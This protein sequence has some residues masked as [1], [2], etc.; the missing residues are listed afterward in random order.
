[1]NKK[2]SIK[3]AVQYV[4]NAEKDKCTLLGI[5]PMS[6]NFHRASLEISKE[7]DF[8]L[9]YIASRNQV[10][11]YKFGGGYVFNSDQKL[12]REKIEKICKEI[13]YDNVYYLCREHGGPWQRDKER[14]DHLPEDV[15]TLDENTKLQ[16]TELCGHYTYPKPEVEA[17][18]EKLYNNLNKVNINGRRYVVEKLKEEMQKH[19]RCFNLEGLTSKI[20]ASC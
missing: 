11:A 1:M 10:D 17:E 20:E 19:V 14:N 9:M 4:V 18:I 12:F 16:I 13:D 8:P 15:A 5:G 6:E 3:K 7:K 2:V